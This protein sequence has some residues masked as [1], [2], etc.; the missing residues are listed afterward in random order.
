M[1]VNITTEDR[2]K[3][4]MIKQGLDI[5]NKILVADLCIFYLQAQIDQLRKNME[6]DVPTQFDTCTEYGVRNITNI[7]D[8]KESEVL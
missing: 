8:N 5:N 6:K 3:L 2:V 4:L 1:I 7:T